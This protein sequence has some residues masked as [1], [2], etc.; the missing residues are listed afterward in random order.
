MDEDSCVN[1]NKYVL[2]PCVCVSVCVCGVC[3]CVCMCV[4]VCVCNGSGKSGGRITIV[5]RDLHTYTLYC[6]G[7]IMRGCTRVAAVEKDAVG[8][9]FCLT[10]AHQTLLHEAVG[11]SE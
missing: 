9:Q 4:C 7:V 10:S 6:V 5:M 8:E 3:V 1:F 11:A 2:Y